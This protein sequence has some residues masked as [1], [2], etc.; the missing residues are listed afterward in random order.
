M[1]FKMHVSQLSVPK[2][3]AEL[4][5]LAGDA[6]ANL[7]K[8]EYVPLL[9][10]A[11]LD[12]A[13]QHHTQAQK[14]WKEGVD[15]MMHNI[16]RDCD[17]VSDGAQSIA[18]KA[19]ATTMCCL[20]TTARIPMLVAEQ[21]AHLATAALY[22][23]YLQMKDRCVDQGMFFFQNLTWRQQTAQNTILQGGRSWPSQYTSRG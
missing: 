6:P 1:I 9:I 19:A 20:D 5:R 7:S 16:S 12:T 3:K 23:D 18:P 21:A 15:K 2:I 22:A 17:I 13:R 8:N 10:E 4:V 11:K 14:V